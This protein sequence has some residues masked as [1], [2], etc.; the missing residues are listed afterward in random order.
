MKNQMSNFLSTSSRHAKK[1]INKKSFYFFIFI[2]IISHL[3]TNLIEQEL[4]ST[5]ANLTY[6]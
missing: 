2:K 5:K 4:I 1:V 3:I 6:F